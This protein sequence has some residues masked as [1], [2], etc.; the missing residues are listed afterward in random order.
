MSEKR[1]RVIRLTA[2][3]TVGGWDIDIK[4]C[5]ATSQSNGYQLLPRTHH[6]EL[7]KL[8]VVEHPITQFALF[9]SE[10]IC[11]P[12]DIKNALEILKRVHMEEIFKARLGVMQMCQATSVQEAKIDESLVNYIKENCSDG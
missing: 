8:M 2:T 6:K 5:W 9:S 10:I 3:S 7:S 12:K 4:Q 1:I 11:L